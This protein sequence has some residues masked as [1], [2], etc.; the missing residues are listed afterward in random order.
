M[1]FNHLSKTEIF[2]IVLKVFT[3]YLGSILSGDTCGRV[4]DSQPV[5]GGCPRKNSTCRIVGGIPANP[6]SHPWQVCT[7]RLFLFFKSEFLLK[8]FSYI[9]DWAYFISKSKS[10]ISFRV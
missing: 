6:G 2:S 1:N 7:S 9:D 3:C 4:I 10:G 5:P 8:I